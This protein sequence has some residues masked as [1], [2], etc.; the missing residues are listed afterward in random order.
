MH[1][2]RLL[3]LSINFLL[4][5]IYLS[6]FYYFNL[7]RK[8]HKTG[9]GKFEKL[10]GYSRKVYMLNKETQEIMQKFDSLADAGRYL[11]RNPNQMGSI[12]AQIR[13]E[14][15][16]AYGYKWRYVDETND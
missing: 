8:V 11:K 13:G 4:S 5:C 1:G 3:S 10:N 7:I 2:E 6:F 12:A 15:K 14:R 9:T 16:T